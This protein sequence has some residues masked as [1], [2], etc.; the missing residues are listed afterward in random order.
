MTEHRQATGEAAAPKP[1]PTPSPESGPFWAAAKE[2]RLSLQRCGVCG[3][4]RFPPSR[5]CPHCF[6][7]EFVWFDVTGKGRIHSFVVV[8]RATQK[9]FAVVPYV[10]AVIELEEGA[11]MVSNIL[12]DKIETLRCGM[13]VRV[14]FETV[15]EEMAVPRFVLEEHQA[16][17]S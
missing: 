2:S 3:R 5:V 8:H 6:S 10:V 11:R 12:T 9:A 7:D 14:C 13:P 15:T 16:K 1:A 17:R 4:F